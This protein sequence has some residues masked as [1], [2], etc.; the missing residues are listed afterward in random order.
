M[1]ANRATQDGAREGLKMPQLT[2][3]TIEN[4]RRGM[5]E[6][7]RRVYAAFK[8]RPPASDEQ[9]AE[10]NRDY[11][12][13]FQPRHLGTSPFPSTA[14]NEAMIHVVLSYGNGED[15]SVSVRLRRPPK[16]DVLSLAVV[17]AIT[18]GVREYD[19]RP[20]GPESPGDL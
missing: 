12:E 13:Q 19:H 4:I 1:T 20:L 2:D 5:S 3:L 7:F 6:R 15:Y 17:R 16:P 8:N 11:M 14:K 18:K 10:A 9:I